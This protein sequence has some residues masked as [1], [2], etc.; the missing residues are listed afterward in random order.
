MPRNTLIQ[1]RRGTEAQLAGV[2]LGIGELGFTTDTRKLYIGTAT[3][4][5]AVATGLQIT[6]ADINA[7]PKGPVTWNQLK[8]M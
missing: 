1:I 7:M 8:G 4:N 3:G 6:P 5:Y 2:V